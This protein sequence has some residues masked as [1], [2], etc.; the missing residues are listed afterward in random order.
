MKKILIVDDNNVN[1]KILKLILNEMNVELLYAKNGVEA[2]D[3]CKLNPDIPLVLM[4]IR[5]PI[6][7]GDDAA[8]IIKG[9]NST[10]KIF[11]I[12]AGC[13]KNLETGNENIFDE[14]FQI[15][16]NFEHIKKK[17]KEILF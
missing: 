17:T 14:I 1:I 10:I 2:I 6:M 13:V 5:M 3:I 11:A 9:E 16:F 15:P 4:D 12:T 7:S 8:A